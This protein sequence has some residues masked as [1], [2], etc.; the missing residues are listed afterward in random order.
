VWPAT[1]AVAVVNLVPLLEMATTQAVLA[2]AGATIA[3]LPSPTIEGPLLWA[4]I[5]SVVLLGLAETFRSGGRLT[6]D[7]EGLV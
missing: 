4:V 3:L 5:G 1:V 7:V 2:F 6:R